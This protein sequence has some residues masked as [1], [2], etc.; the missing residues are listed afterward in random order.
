LFTTYLLNKT[1]NHSS[2]YTVQFTLLLLSILRQHVF[3]DPLI[4]ALH[5]AP[6]QAYATLQGMFEG[7]PSNQGYRQR[8]HEEYPWVKDVLEYTPTQLP[9]LAWVLRAAYSAPFLGTTGAVLKGYQATKTYLN[10][11]TQ[12]SAVLQ[13]GVPGEFTQ[14]GIDL[15]ETLENAEEYLGINDLEEATGFNVEEVIITIAGY[16]DALN[17][18]LHLKDAP[19]RRG[20]RSSLKGSIG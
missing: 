11:G 20:R 5:A 16:Q 4:Q 10:F 18:F 7:V 19:Q 3:E 13:G 14:G 1:H 2:T 9:G 17:V 15:V 6:R 12:A 8:F